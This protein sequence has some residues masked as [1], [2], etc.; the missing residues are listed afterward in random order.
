MLVGC[1]DVLELPLPPKSQSKSN[2]N[3]STS[4]VSNCPS[5]NVY[6]AFRLS[7]VVVVVVDS[8]DCRDSW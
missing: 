7:A 3:E 2:P 1:D 8:Y 4:H 5:S 6:A